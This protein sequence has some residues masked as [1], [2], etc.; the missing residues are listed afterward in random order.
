MRS[1][2]ATT[3]IN[4]SHNHLQFYI[5]FSWLT[6][7]LLGLHIIPGIAG[8][9]SWNP[10]NDEIYIRHFL[11]LLIVGYIPIGLSVL[12]IVRYRLTWI[13]ILCFLKSL[14]FGF[15]L[16]LLVICFSSGAWLGRI[17]YLFADSINTCMLLWFWLRQ[18]SKQQ[19]NTCRDAVILSCT[20]ICCCIFESFVLSPFLLNH[21]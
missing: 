21:L 15:S 16:H 1:R 3:Q 4:L 12:L 19:E 2:K 6:G 10:V 11:S 18:G 13:P 5:I 14:L 8:V 9:V 7:L 20:H 17:L